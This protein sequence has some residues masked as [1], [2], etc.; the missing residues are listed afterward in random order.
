MY[1]TFMKNVSTGMG[2]RCMPDNCITELITSLYRNDYTLNTPHASVVQIN[3]YIKNKGINAGL[4]TL[5]SKLKEDEQRVYNENTRA[6]PV[7]LHMCN[8][9]PPRPPQHIDHILNLY[10]LENLSK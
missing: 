2:I 1:E 6:N 7:D 4:F 10:G 8:K 5:I 9:A 3:A